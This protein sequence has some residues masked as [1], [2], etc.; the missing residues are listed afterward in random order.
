MKEKDFLCAVKYADRRYFCMAETRA[1]LAAAA[2]KKTERKIPMTSFITRMIAIG[3]GA[4]VC[5][6]IALFALLPNPNSTGTKPLLPAGTTPP[7]SLEQL[8][9]E[10]DLADLSCFGVDIAE[11]K[12]MGEYFQDPAPK[13]EWLGAGEKPDYTWFE[14]TNKSGDSIVLDNEGRVRKIICEVILLTSAEPNDMP[15]ARFSGDDLF[16]IGQ[17]MLE[18]F[19]Y[20]GKGHFADYGAEICDRVFPAENGGY[21]YNASLL[22]TFPQNGANTKNIREAFI[23]LDGDSKLRYLEIDYDPLLPQKTVDKL[24]ALMNEHFA[25]YID[26]LYGDTVESHDEIESSF[27]TVDGKA[28]VSFCAAVHLKDSMAENPTKHTVVSLLI[29]EDGSAK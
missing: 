27:F 17:E 6:G 7:A 22:V 18:Q 1:E 12:Y 4:A 20:N 9:K 26:K 13:Y 2:D 24:T 16:A 14:Y 19:V 5:G 3:A 28:Y 23:E 29:G 25:L 10:N 15:A 11:Y 8:Y 21:P